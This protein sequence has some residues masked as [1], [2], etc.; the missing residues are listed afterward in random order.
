[1][2]KKTRDQIKPRKTED[3]KHFN[4]PE[5]VNQDKNKILLI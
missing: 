2:I 4:R 5:E 1:M 3:R